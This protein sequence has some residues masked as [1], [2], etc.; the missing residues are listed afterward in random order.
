MD[1]RAC[2]LCDLPVSAHPIVEGE[3]AFCC[4]GCCTVYS[5]LSTKNQ[6][7]GYAENP[8][9]LQAV[10]SGLISNPKLIEEIK[11]SKPSV[12]EGE[13]EKIHLEIQN[14]WC[15][16]CA[17]VIKL[18][19][20]REKGVIRCVVDY[21][22][23]LAMI[24]FSPRYISKEGLYD[25]ISHLG[26][27]P[28]D[29]GSEEK[30]VVSKDL[31]FRFVIGAFFSLNIM[32][33]SYPIYAS[34]FDYDPEGY[35]NV[36]AWISF[37]FALPVLLFSGWPILKR[38]VGS[39][40]LGILGMESLVVMGVLAAFGLSLY[41]LFRGGSHVYFD[42]MSVIIVFVLL[43]KI[44]ESKAKF[45][46][47]ESM[48]RLSR[49][50]PRRGRIVSPDGTE[51]FVPIKEIH[52]GMH[53]LAKAGEK[54]VL[55]GVVVEGKG[56][57]DESLMTG[58]AVPVVKQV[59]DSVLA[60]TVIQ[61]GK[62]KY[63]ATKTMEETA[64]H[65]IVEMVEKDV[66]FKTTY[67]RMADKVV[68]WF[69]PVVLSIAFSTGLLSWMLGWTTLEV[70]IL[71][72]ISIVLISCPC[73]IG[74]A[75]PLAESHLINGLA[76]LGV[77]VRN[78]GCLALLGKESVWVFDKTGT[79]TEGKF[80][81]IDGL[82]D[83]SEEEK[84]FLKGLTEHSV[85]PISQAIDQLLCDVVPKVFDQIEEVVGLGLV[86]RFGEQNYWLGSQELKARQ[87]VPGFLETHRIK[88]GIGPI[89]TVYYGFR[90]RCIAE[91][92]LGDT[93]RSEAREVIASLSPSRTVLL[94]GDAEPPVAAIGKMCGF[95]DWKWRQSPLHKREFI[96]TLRQSG[97]IVAMCGDGI[98]D[99]PALTGAHIGISVVNA[100]DVSIQVSDILLTTDHLSVIQKMRKLALRGKKIVKQNL[101]WA[102]F[103]NTVGI[104]L[105]A[106]GLLNPL[107][108]AVAMVLSSVIVV[109]NA[110]RL[111]KVEG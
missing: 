6:L 7:G 102:F 95:S 82:N 91:I 26:Y 25:K 21:C 8:L 41:E 31:M 17:E 20:L 62:I 73:A 65:K 63:S 71:R 38:C 10:K 43:G 5:I 106:F 19:L 23:D 86:G 14:M 89:S 104:G 54:I 74:I 30:R 11:L 94:S 69:V 75:A 55:D 50:L 35:A 80:S 40:L 59:G 78:R 77:I 66:G 60:G 32:M 52:P 57:C 85:H 2:A 88:E 46:A 96:D 1:S 109:C 13:N 28:L 27:L 58:E 97:E 111:G 99:A 4:Y 36:F 49:S 15:P 56:M 39:C 90:D 44:I 9:F 12:P 34:Y 79:I 107:F 72:A 83:L 29:L 24:E 101:F 64:L 22:T 103:Y 37:I 108:A 110:R 47:K 18:I 92:F 16:S 67:V 33:L 48:I 76:S 81:V 3:N 84:S 53:V 98:N 42:S 70:A 68:A 93:I 51:T 61:Q 87:G 100:A 45:S 105:A